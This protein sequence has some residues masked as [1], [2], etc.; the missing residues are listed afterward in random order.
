[1]HVSRTLGSE[2]SVQSNQN[3][4][5]GREPWEEL[6]SGQILL[7]IWL[8]SGVWQEIKKLKIKKEGSKF[9]QPARRHRDQ[10]KRP[11]VNFF[12]GQFWWTNLCNQEHV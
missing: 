8:D 4:G 1:M 10:K 12:K 5:N 6:E 9:K 3:P 2:Y 11:W 7:K